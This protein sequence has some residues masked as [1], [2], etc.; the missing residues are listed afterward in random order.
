MD[1]DALKKV[2]EGIQEAL[3]M[4]NKGPKK[5]AEHP[6]DTYENIREKLAEKVEELANDPSKIKEAAK[7]VDDLVK[8][9]D[10]TRQSV[11]AAGC[12]CDNEH[13]KT[14]ILGLPL[15]NLAR[16]SNGDYKLDLSPLGLPITICIVSGIGYENTMTNVI[17]RIDQEPGEFMLSYPGK[18][19]HHLY[20][21]TRPKD[22]SASQ[23]KVAE[24]MGKEMVPSRSH[25]A[26]D[27]DPD[28]I[29]PRQ[30]KTA[31]VINFAEHKKE[32]LH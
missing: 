6:K 32:T 25:S 15:S 31:N 23:L 17:R 10:D 24:I 19:L 3:D 13:H 27:V 30:P 1:D 11:L 26:D 14:I 16:L 9:A 8:Q 5:Q 20:P 28:F 12:D 29:G 2:L 21:F 22:M 7:Q 4:L 18:S